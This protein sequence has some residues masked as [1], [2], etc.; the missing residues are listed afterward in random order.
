MYWIIPKSVISLITSAFTD[1][2]K[3]TDLYEKGI[4]EVSIYPNLHF[5]TGDKIR[6]GPLAVLMGISL[7]KT[8]VSSKFA[9]H[10]YM[11]HKNECAYAYHKVWLL[12]TCAY[13]RSVR[14]NVLLN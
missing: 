3:I 5:S 13:T 2:S 6:V 4:T 1:R 11:I 8:Q 14:G 12:S 9:L 10:V 7:E